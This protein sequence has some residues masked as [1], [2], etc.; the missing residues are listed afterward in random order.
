MFTNVQLYSIPFTALIIVVLTLIISIYTYTKEYQVIQNEDESTI[1]LPQSNGFT[2]T[3]ENNS[4]I[5]QTSV[6]GILSNAIQ[7]K[8]TSTSSSDITKTKL[9]N[10]QNI[11]QNETQISANDTTLIGIEKACMLKHTKLKQFV[12]N[13][14]PIDT[15]DSVF[16]ILEKTQSYM[17]R[18]RFLFSCFE[19]KIIT[20]TY[21]SLWSGSSN[22]GSSS[23]SANVFTNQTCIEFQT[24]AKLNVTTTSGSLLIN[25]IIN[26]TI[27]N[28]ILIPF[29]SDFSFLIISSKFSFH[30][31]I[32]TC[33]NTISIS[34]KVNNF[35][36]VYSKQ[37]D[38]N[39]NPSI[40]NI[41][42][43]FAQVLGQD[44]NLEFQFASGKFVNE[45]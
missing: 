19:P 25:T 7:D 44:N 9:N 1:V 41:H 21:S 45:S 37:T 8:I 40:I 17:N 31:S 28:S 14:N 42:E 15:Q 38:V 32:L 33:L 39:F 16:T 10:Y 18:N 3:K 27:I 34:N 43:Q 2:S 35:L 20:T 5:L 11:S 6:S 30:G 24:F 23:F 26:E 36:N 29:Q 4:L 12:A 22:I 13:K